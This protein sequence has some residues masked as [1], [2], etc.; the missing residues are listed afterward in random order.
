MQQPYACGD[1]L[2][3]VAS[4]ANSNVRPLRTDP[5]DCRTSGSQEAENHI[6]AAIMETRPMAKE[7]AEEI[8]RDCQKVLK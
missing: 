3:T 1:N 6:D 5:S 4:A 2:E 8:L 7:S